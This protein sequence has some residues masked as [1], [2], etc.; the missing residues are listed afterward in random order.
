MMSRSFYILVVLGVFIINAFTIEARFIPEDTISSI[1]NDP[2][3]DEHR[4]TLHAITG[5][6]H[7]FEQSANFKAL[8]WAFRDGK[9]SGLCDL[10]DIGVPLVSELIKIFNVLIVYSFI[11][12][13][14][15]SIIF[16]T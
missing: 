11:Y 1:L 15:G 4:K 13:I 8:R 12:M 16:G 5:Y 7:R 6:R 14:I 2:L 3:S 9:A 10:C